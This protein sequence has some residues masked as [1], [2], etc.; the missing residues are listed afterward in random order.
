MARKC[1]VERAKQKSGGFAKAKKNI[2]LQF[3]GREIQE[4]NI[5]EKVKQHIL[6][7]GIEEVD[8]EKIDLYIKPEEQQ[9]YYVVNNQQTG[10]IGL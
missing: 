4:E 2:I 5:L 1:S 7:S 9:V 6:E 10:C 3:Q 8:I